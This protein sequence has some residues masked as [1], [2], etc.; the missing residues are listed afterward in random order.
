VFAVQGLEFLRRDLEGDEHFVHETHDQVDDAFFFFA[1]LPLGR[2]VFL[3][4]DA[5]QPFGRHDR[6]RTDRDR[7]QVAMQRVHGHGVFRAAVGQ[8]ETV[9]FVEFFVGEG[10]VE[11]H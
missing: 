2:D 11:L 9:E 6:L 3:A 7:G 8:Q 1:V 5:R 10:L 4:P